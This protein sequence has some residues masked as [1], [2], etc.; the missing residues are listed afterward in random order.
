MRLVQIGFMNFRSFGP[1]KK[2]DDIAKMSDDDFEFID[3][4]EDIVFL[5]GKNNS[6]KSNVIAGIEKY[7]DAKATMEAADFFRRGGDC[8]IIIDGVIQASEDELVD[9]EKGK[10]PVSKWFGDTGTEGL[11]SARIR[12]V[13]TNPVATPEKYSY[14][15]TKNE[16]VKGG[17]GGFDTILQNRLPKPIKIHGFMTPEE[18]I[19]TLQSIIKE[20]V[21][22]RLNKLDEYGAA[23][24]ALEALAGKIEDDEFKKGIEEK[25]SN[26][27][28][29]VFPG[30]AARILN[31]ADL[32]KLSSLIEKSAYISVIEEYLVEGNEATLELELNRHGHG[33]RRQF[34][35]SAL[36]GAADEFIR[37]R[38]Q[39]KDRDFSKEADFGDK[40]LLI[41]EPELFLHP[42]ACR[43]VQSILYDVAFNTPFQVVAA[44]HSPILIDLSRSHQSLVRVARKQKDPASR[45]IQV[46]W[47]LF[48]DNE[49]SQMLMITRFDSHVAESFFS[50]DVI[51]VEGDT[52][53]VAIRTLM[54]R[55]G[56]E[57]LIPPVPDVLVVNALSKA[58]IPL[59]QKICRHFEIDYWVLHDVDAPGADGA[60]TAMWTMNDRIYN[61]IETAKIYETAAS[62]FLFFRN[63][64]DAHGY[65]HSTSDGKPYS[66]MR[67]VE[68][69]ADI[70][71][72]TS[73]LPLVR[74]V[75]HIFGLRQVKVI[76]DQAF[77]EEAHKADKLTIP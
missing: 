1:G 21:I 24:S 22:I 31:P 71:P 12:R 55:M 67:Q 36:Q 4:E 15:P 30:F 42:Y 66:A 72:T 27:L 39:K 60:A 26:V 43:V 41:E 62:R 23:V 20:A 74:Y 53:K 58:N 59:F 48:D 10:D 18:V 44:T 6:G 56:V 40:L 2:I 16:W 37:M 33:F 54:S 57:G 50:D 61:E 34:I 68:G 63:F 52:E 19:S 3:L 64:E 25:L 38:Q 73:D 76:M 75:G 29:Q 46:D 45:V 70:N 17:F 47:D 65:K 5:I 35:L 51:I 32:T 28:S 7:C 8:P 11:K 14:D 69:W 9:E 49:R 13:W 77:L